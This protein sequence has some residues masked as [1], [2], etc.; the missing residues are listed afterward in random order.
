MIYHRGLSDH[1]LK[2][3]YTYIIAYLV[4]LHDVIHTS[5]EDASGSR[6]VI[7]FSGFRNAVNCLTELSIAT[8]LN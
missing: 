8:A 7:S 2:P 4:F 5:P 6:Y 3:Y 1:T